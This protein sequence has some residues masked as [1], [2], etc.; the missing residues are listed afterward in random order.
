MGVATDDTAHLDGFRVVPARELGRLRVYIK[1]VAGGEDCPDLMPPFLLL[2]VPETDPRADA[3]QDMALYLGQAMCTVM[4]AGAGRD[5]LFLLA[6][7]FVQAVPDIVPRYA[8]ESLLPPDGGP[9]FIWKK[10]D[11][12]YLKVQ[13]GDEGFA[14][15]LSEQER[16]QLL[17]DEA[18]GD[19]SGDDWP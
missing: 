9:T 7:K 14:E 16:L 1:F 4:N 8:L 12:T 13:E 15:A 19:G 18:K 2:D 17:R 6:D 10:P 3:A 5:A 11:G